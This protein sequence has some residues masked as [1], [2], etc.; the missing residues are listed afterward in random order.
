MAAKPQSSI[1]NNPVYSFSMKR[2]ILSGILVIGVATQTP[3]A[4]APIPTVSADP[5]ASAMVVDAANGEV[6]FEEN[7]DAVLFPASI[8]KLMM[9]LLILEHIETGQLALTDQIGVTAEAER[10]G[11]AQVYLATGESFTLREMLFALSIKSANDV[12]VALAIHIAGSKE[13]FVRMMNE[14]AAELG[15]GATRFASV[16]GLP[17]EEGQEPDRS[18]ARDVAQLCRKILQNPNALE[19]TSAKKGWFRNNTFEMLSH[20][21]LLHNVEG[22]DGLKTGYF[23]AAGFSV[24]AT[25]QRNGRRVIAVVMGS[26]VRQ[27]RDDKAAALINHGFANLPASTTPPPPRPSPKIEP[28]AAPPILETAEVPPAPSVTD[29]ESEDPATVPETED[30]GHRFPWL[31]V[32]MAPFAVIGVFTVLRHFRVV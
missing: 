30:D 28:P 27:T 17:P 7:A 22:C 32:V 31:T 15:L 8:V 1:G 18:T 20:N 19:Y 23:R 6:L 9:M 14:R 24:A 12:A 11:G 10:M 3:A 21:R 16:H 26:K 25:A 4:R 2:L 5:Y 13:A 29:L